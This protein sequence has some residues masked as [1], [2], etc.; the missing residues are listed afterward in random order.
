[1]IEKIM[2]FIW[3]FFVGMILSYLIMYLLISVYNFGFTNPA[4]WP[5]LGRAC[6]TAY[7]IIVGIIL[8]TYN[9]NN[10]E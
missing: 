3:L 10:I 9:A 4:E 6:I 1:M 7:S 2:A 5:E 8:A